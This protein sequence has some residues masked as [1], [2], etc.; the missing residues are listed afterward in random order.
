MALTSR[1]GVAA[2]RTQAV[3][4][5]SPGLMPWACSAH[6]D[7]HFMVSPSSRRLGCSASRTASAPPT[8]SMAATRRA[9]ARAER[10][11]DVAGAAG[12]CGC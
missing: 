10:D 11:G 9:C 12:C 7:D 1:T 2:S 5:G 4:I 8:R 3:K 6:T